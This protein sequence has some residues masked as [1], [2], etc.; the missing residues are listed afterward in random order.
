MKQDALKIFVLSRFFLF[1]E[2]RPFEI[3][4]KAERM[5]K[6]EKEYKREQR[7]ANSS[8]VNR[9]SSSFVFAISGML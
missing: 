1:A 7:S 4:A 9:S 2:E 3:Q 8:L 5:V 6:I